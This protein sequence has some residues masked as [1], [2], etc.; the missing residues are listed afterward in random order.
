MW[1]LFS[2]A[3]QTFWPPFLTEHRLA[4]LQP[5]TILCSK[6]PLGKCKKVPNIP[7]LEPAWEPIMRRQRSTIFRR[8]GKFARHHEIVAGGTIPIWNPTNQI[9]GAQPEWF[10]GT[11]AKLNFFWSLLSWNCGCNSTSNQSNQ[12]SKFLLKVH[13]Q[14]D[15]AP[16][17]PTV[18]R[19]FLKE[20]EWLKLYSKIH[21]KNAYANRISTSSVLFCNGTVK[22]YKYTKIVPTVY[23]T[24]TPKNRNTNSRPFASIFGK[25]EVWEQFLKAF[26]KFIHMCWITYRAQRVP[27]YLQSSP[28][29]PRPK[30]YVAYV[31][32]F[33]SEVFG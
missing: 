1:I 24:K 21:S 16:Y 6:R 13:T 11:N 14:R 26:Q 3:F 25:S 8:K 10:W 29:T 9:S 4:S 15:T 30:S 22:F 28:T 2:H 27:K 19:S 7:S 33:W 32:L 31:K 23:H 12:T 17:F 18:L 5:A 20:S